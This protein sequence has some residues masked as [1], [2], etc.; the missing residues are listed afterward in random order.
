MAEVANAVGGHFL[1]T[2]PCVQRISLPPCHWGDRYKVMIP[3]IWIDTKRKQQHPASILLILSQYWPKIN[4]QYDEICQSV[5]MMENC[6]KMLL[7][8]ARERETLGTV[9]RR[10]GAGGKL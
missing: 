6:R 2:V 7:L 1:P 9:H 10:Q 8:Q 3:N 4:S 5:R